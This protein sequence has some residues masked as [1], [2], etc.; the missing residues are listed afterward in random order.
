VGRIAVVDVEDV[1]QSGEVELGERDRDRT[2]RTERGKS[3]RSDVIR[4]RVSLACE[5]VTARSVPVAM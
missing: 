5:I 1:D 3:C 4:E 2:R